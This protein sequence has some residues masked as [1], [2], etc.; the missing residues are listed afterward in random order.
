MG[1]VYGDIWFKVAIK[2][3][4]KRRLD[5][6]NLAKIYREILVLKRIRH[7]HIIKLYQVG[8]LST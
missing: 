8:K 1:L 6:D 2:I 5:S 4:D 3:V 7:P